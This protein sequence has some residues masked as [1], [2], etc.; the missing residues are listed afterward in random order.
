M[1]DGRPQWVNT[2]DSCK[3]IKKI[4]LDM[5]KFSELPANREKLINIK[6]EIRKRTRGENENVYINQRIVLE[7]GG[8]EYDSAARTAL[9]PF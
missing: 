3:P 5:D 6:L 7:D 2:I 4:I 8:N 9:A 1:L